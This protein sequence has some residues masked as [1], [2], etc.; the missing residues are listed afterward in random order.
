MP[1]YDGRW[2]R[3]SEAERREF[4]RRKAEDMSKKWHAKYISKTRLKQE[5]SWTDAMIKRFLRPSQCGIPGVSAYLRTSV[6]KAEQK[7]EVQAWLVKRTKA[8]VV[9]IEPHQI[10]TTG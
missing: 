8:R 10:V 1:W 3:Y 5:R 2:H 7:P 4:G 9:P 6:L